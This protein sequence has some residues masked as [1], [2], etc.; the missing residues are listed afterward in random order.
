LRL[1]VKLIDKKAHLPLFVVWVTRI[2]LATHF[3]GIHA[4]RKY[5]FWDA[6][7]AYLKLSGR[8][9]PFFCHWRRSASPWFTPLGKRTGYSDTKPHQTKIFRTEKSILYCLLKG[10]LQ[11]KLQSDSDLK[12]GPRI[13]QGPQSICF[14]IFAFFFL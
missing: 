3:V 7:G 13:Y 1:K 2:E 8:S 10:L 14:Q 5:F 4:S 12:N 9:P 11:S 6:A